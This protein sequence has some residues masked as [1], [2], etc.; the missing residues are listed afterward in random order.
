MS[1]TEFSEQI[2]YD[3]I[4]APH[5]DKVVFLLAQLCSLVYNAWLRGK[6]RAL[7]PEDF[8][9]KRAGPRKQQTA[10]EMKAILK[11]YGKAHNAWLQQSQT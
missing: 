8:L 9:P 7:K 4:E 3:R 1:S 10:A 5:E 11:A 2:A 6:G